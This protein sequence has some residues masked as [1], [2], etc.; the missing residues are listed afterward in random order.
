M[1]YYHVVFLAYIDQC[2][3]IGRCLWWSIGRIKLGL[4]S[5]IALW[6]VLHPLR[7]AEG[8]GWHVGLHLCNL[9]I[10]SLAALHWSN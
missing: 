4:S 6:D 8:Q 1:N 3:Q 2:S 5:E 9:I 7:V 10:I